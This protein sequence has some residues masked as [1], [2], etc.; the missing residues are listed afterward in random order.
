LRITVKALTFADARRELESLLRTVCLDHE[1]AVVTRV[2]AEAVVLISV[3]DYESLVR[4]ASAGTT[5][6]GTG[7]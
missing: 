5:L 4:T 3:K 6:V 2:A 7:C 1:P